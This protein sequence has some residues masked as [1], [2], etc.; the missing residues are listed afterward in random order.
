MV[1]YCYVTENAYTTVMG[2]ESDVYSYGVVLLE[3]ISR[4]KAIDPSFM[5]GMDIVSWVRSLWEE[6]GVVDEIVDSELANEISRYNSNVMKEVTKVLLVAFKCT[7]RDPRRRPTMR[8][9]IKNL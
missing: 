9:V 7:E 3:L 4:K 2:K 8:D 1:K 5:E 6:T